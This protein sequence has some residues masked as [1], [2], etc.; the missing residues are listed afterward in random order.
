MQRLIVLLGVVVVLL[1]G[2]A[3][4]AAQ[5]SGSTTVTIIGLTDYHS[6]AVSFYSE[7]KPNQA[8]IARTIAYL[9][10]AK[11]E[12]N[13]IVVSGGDTM[14][15]GIPTWSDEYQC[16]EWPWFNGLVDVMALGN[17]DLDYGA[18]AFAQCRASADYPII[19]ANL[20][21]ADGTPFLQP[22]GKPYV[23]KEIDGVKIGFFAV[24]GP[25]VQRLI[26]KEWLPEGTSWQDATATARTIVARLRSEEQVSAVVLIGHQLREDD[27]ALARAVPGIDLIM[28][29]H[30]HYKGELSKIE[31]TETYYISPF[32][33]L[34]YLARVQLTFEG[35]KL[36]AVTGELVKMDESRPEDPQIAAQVAQLQQALVAKRPERFEVLGQAQR[37]LSDANISRGESLIGNWATEVL[38]QAAGAHAFLST[39]SSFRAALPPGDITVEG[40]YTA[41]PYKNIITTAEM[42]GQQLADLVALSV[43]KMGSDGFSQVSGVRYAV[44]DGKP[45]NIQVLRDPANPAAGYAPLDPAATY[46]VG[47]TDFQAYVAGGYKELFAQAQNLTKSDMDAHQTLISAIRAGPI[48]ASLDGRT[49]AG[50][51]PA[52]L[53]TTGQEP[54]G[55]LALLGAGVALLLGGTALRRRW[56][57]A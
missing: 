30:S 20:V 10:A 33:Y 15:L 27:E 21:T 35:G 39:A 32:Q 55:A 14:N 22:E 53:P 6:H 11:Q 23:V 56:R 44:Q 40:F 3:P 51:A 57:A 24:G 36:A 41:I 54:G 47:T 25:D 19:S 7:G 17:H 49:S 45:T 26:K 42:R 46:R 29:S 2:A 12:P 13:T 16:I 38:R 4:L 43:N 9:K 18:A 50:S 8:G 52:T 1:L 48:T 34:T 31:G 37:E 28:G 5:S